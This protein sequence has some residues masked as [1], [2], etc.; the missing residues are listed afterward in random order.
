M[1]AIPNENN[2]LR[3]IIVQKKNAGYYECAGTSEGGEPF[4]AY[5]ELKVIGKLLHLIIL[6]SIYYN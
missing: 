1:N 6:P 4:K 5:G 2:E 3:I